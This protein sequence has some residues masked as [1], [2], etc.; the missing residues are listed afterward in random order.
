VHTIWDIHVRY[1]VVTYIKKADGQY[2]ES[3]QL[4]EEHLTNKINVTASI[5]LDF[6]ETKVLKA[7]LEEP[8]ERNWHLIRNYFYQIYPSIID[9]IEKVW[10]KKEEPANTDSPSADNEST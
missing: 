7:R 8:I 10:D 1:F 3:V 6:K 2:D 5:I 9:Q 4:V